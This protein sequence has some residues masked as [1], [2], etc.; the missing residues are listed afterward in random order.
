MYPG[1][2]TESEILSVPRYLKT[3]PGAP[4]THL[5]Y[6]TDDEADLLE[7]YKPD[8]PHRGPH[9]VPN[10][11]SFSWDPDTGAALESG[12]GS[13]WSGGTAWSSTGGSEG[14]GG[15][16]GDASYEEVWAHSGGQQ[17][18]TYQP[19]EEVY[20]PNQTGV[21]P[22]ETA[23]NWKSMDANNPV[24]QGVWN[25]V[26]NMFKS[27]SG[28]RT[29]EFYGIVKFNNNTGKYEWTQTSNQG[30]QLPTEFINSIAEGSIVSGNEAVLSNEPWIGTWSD[31]GAGNH[32]MFPGGL[33]DYYIATRDPFIVPYTG[34]GGGRGGSAVVLLPER[35]L[36]MNKAIEQ[37]EDKHG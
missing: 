24:H 20:G 9:D 5:A 27:G 22:G 12:S 2:H 17:P 18:D 26:K 30:R 15:Q 1:N 6:I 16:T 28:M 32:P 31:V 4:E 14:T 36:K 34:S 13:D 33:E 37:V 8:T 11:D 19:P 23:Y 25:T 7:I 29:L 3:R 10:Y 21:I 35:F